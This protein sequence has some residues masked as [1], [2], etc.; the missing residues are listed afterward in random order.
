MRDLELLQV[1]LL[2]CLDRSLDMGVCRQ[3]QEV[4]GGL[5][6]AL[7]GIAGRYRRTGRVTHWVELAEERF[8]L[9]R[10]WV[11][12]QRPTN[13]ALPLLDAVATPRAR[14]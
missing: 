14:P 3:V 6:G 7:F 4:P 10:A 11:L 13:R 5:T 1:G 12:R 2:A 8:C 9:R